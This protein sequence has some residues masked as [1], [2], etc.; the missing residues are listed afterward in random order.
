MTACGFWLTAKSDA[1][2]YLSSV[3]YFLG[4][5]TKIVSGKKGSVSGL[6]TGETVAA[7]GSRTKVSKYL[8]K[9]IKPIVCAVGGMCKPNTS[10]YLSTSIYTLLLTRY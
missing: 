10:I 4:K 2:Y 8:R 1:A 9:W 3:A 7:E 5:K 6:V